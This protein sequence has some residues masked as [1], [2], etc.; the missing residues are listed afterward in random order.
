MVVDLLKNVILYLASN[1]IMTPTRLTKFIYMG[2]LKCIRQYNRRLCD[3]DFKR[4]NHGPF[5]QSLYDE[6][7]RMDGNELF[8]SF[9][10]RGNK[11]I[12]LID[13]TEKSTGAALSTEGKAILDE[14]LEE[15]RKKEI[16]TILKYV[17]RTIPFL[18]TNFDTHID[19]D[20]YIDNEAREYLDITV[21]PRANIALVNQI[22]AKFTK[23]TTFRNRPSCLM[24]A[25]PKST[26]AS[27]GR[28]CKGTNTSRVC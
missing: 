17:Y 27:P 9:M 12:T 1:S 11:E 13:A 24:S 14:I 6:I 3:I 19:L 22:A 16:K 4:Y 28:C 25:Y 2:E 8:V 26:W 15:W 5:F 20:K 18:E 7:N 10:T 21:E 23:N